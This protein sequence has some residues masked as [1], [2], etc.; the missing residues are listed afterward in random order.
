MRTSWIG[1]ANGHSFV[2]NVHSPPWRL[3]WCP[4]V[5]GSHGYQ[6]PLCCTEPTTAARAAKP[7]GL[8]SL[9]GSE[10]DTCYKHRSGYL[11]R[12]VMTLT[13]CRPPSSLCSVDMGFH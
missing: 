3:G 13:F 10:Q 6:C 4:G 1:A 5:L 2:I 12:E 11:E 9:F 7:A 8:E